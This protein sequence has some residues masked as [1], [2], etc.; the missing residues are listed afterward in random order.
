MRRYVL[1]VVDLALILLATLIAFAL[2][3]NFE[4]EEDRLSAFSPYLGATAVAALTLISVFGLYRSIWRFS[5]MHDYLR[6]T[7]VMMGV[8]LGSVI[9]CF[10]YNRLEGVARS[11]PFLQ[12]IVGVM[13]LVGA[14]VLHRLRH[15]A[16]QQRKA[17]EAL[18]QM[19]A[20]AHELNVLLV[21][22]TRLTEAYIQALAELGSGRINV[23]GIVGR[24][25]RHVGRL[26]GAL[27][28]LGVPEDIES[29]LNSLEVH[30]VSIDRIVVAAPFIDLSDEAKE[31]LLRIER[32]RGVSLQF[33]TEILGFDAAGQASYASRS[34]SSPGLPNK[35]N[36]ETASPELQA[37][38][39]RQF[40][41]VKRGFDALAA[42][43]ILAVLSPLILL[44]GLLVAA[45]VG[46]PVVFWQRRPG[47]NGKAFHLYKFRTM[48][49]AHAPDGRQL[50]DAER[51]SQVGNFL[52]RTR[53]DELPQLLNILRGDM[54]FVGPRPLL[55]RDQ[56]K[57]SASR[58]LVRPGLTGWAQVV[59]GRDIPPED[60][61]AL[62]VWYVRNA[63]LLLDLEIAARTIPIILLGE[64]ISESL[65][66][67][68]RHDLTE[69]GILQGELV[70][71]L[72]KHL[73]IASP[74]I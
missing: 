38:S 2:R 44:V 4:I 58:L 31:A 32:S 25:D 41:K 11:L 17:S 57:S 1:L 72:E 59:G 34:N 64:R 18:L 49:A 35:L 22:V 28:V 53:L 40:W 5:S 12:G 71:G 8:C 24:A 45:S 39:R 16:R 33:L 6:V 21:G 43:M 65:I 3:E 13:A 7:A 30:G 52:R 27:P 66:E 26:V 36:F 68:A 70:Y 23:A 14:R 37:F 46:F 48:G 29:V 19:P 15:A 20:K 60:K 47:L 51:S 63:S 55:P 10:A 62:D 56:P 42:F 69:P 73:R 74:N 50:S 61:A 67:R 54:S 9:I